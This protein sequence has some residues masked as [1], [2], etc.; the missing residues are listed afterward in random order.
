M[1]NVI[2]CWDDPARLRDLEL[3]LF[4]V[5]KDLEGDICLVERE[6][7]TCR[8]HECT[9][10]KTYHLVRTRLSSHRCDSEPARLLDGELTIRNLVH[11]FAD[12]E[13]DGRAIHTGDFRWLGEGL[14]VSGH[15]AGITNAGTHRAKPFD[16]C[17]KC[18]APG[19]LEGRLCG[20]IVKAPDRRLRGCSVVASYRWLVEPREP[21]LEGRLR[22]TLEGA[23]VCP[24]HA[25]N[26]IDFG[27]FRPG[28]RPNPWSVGGNSFYAKNH[29]GDPWSRA[30]IN[31]FGSH[32]GLDTGYELDIA[33][34]SPASSVQLTLVH[35]SAAASAEAFSGGAGVDSS[36]MSG[37]PNVV[38]TLTLSGSN[39][40]RVVV[41]APQNECLLLEICVE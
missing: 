35:F 30:G 13:P 12:A 9:T 37:P 18:S 19:F 36:A 8:R 27:D 20:T 7:E 41:K 1:N 25:R 29:R 34:G 10:L 40:D 15:I 11:A 21:V 26:C 5:S 22:G 33:L 28:R 24:C 17:Q 31:S 39:I 4:A 14:L 2:D 38:E 6:R 3:C 32:I 23:I 16:E